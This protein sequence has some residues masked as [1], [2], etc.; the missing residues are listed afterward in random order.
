VRT[1][2]FDYELPEDRIAQRPADP[3]D[4]ARLLDTRTL[5]DHRVGDLPD[6]LEPGDLVVVN[7]TRVRAARLKGRR[8]DSGGAV[9]LLL[10]EQLEGGNWIALVRP[11]RRLRR[12]VIVDAGDLV[13]RLETDPTDGIVEL[14]LDVRTGADLEETI[15]AT[16]EM[17]L[18]PYIRER[19]SD[20]DRYQT[21]YARRLGSA[22]APTAGLHLTQAVFDRMAARGIGVASIEL[23]VG[24]GTFRPITSETIEAHEMHAEFVVVEQAAVDAVAA[25][26]RA[27]G[28]VVAVGTTVVRALESA[29]AAGTPAPWQGHTDL[30]ITP[31]HEFHGVD[32]LMTNFHVPRSSLLVLVAA[33]AGDLWRP[34]YEAALARGYRFLSFG[35]AMLF[36]RAS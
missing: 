36:E 12:G 21:T 26:R 19:L 1:D 15:A 11:A 2:S 32:M 18:P 6:L 22:A 5:T 14:S 20:P 25:T 4:S 16:G 13:A 9:E 17:P 8:R 35:D 31:G 34:T 24:L 23:R 33:F 29:A 7:D 3:R 30:Y 10:L 27:G 28:R